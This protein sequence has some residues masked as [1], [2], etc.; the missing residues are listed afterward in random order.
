MRG[1][2][3]VQVFMYSLSLEAEMDNRKTGIIRVRSRIDVAEI[4]RDKVGNRH[5]NLVD[6]IC[7]MV[8]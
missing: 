3:L 2:L 6:T 8:I 4:L 1:Y 5:L 7:A